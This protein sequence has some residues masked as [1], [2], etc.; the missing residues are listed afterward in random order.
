[1]GASSEHTSDLL[2]KQ[3]EIQGSSL[4]LSIEST[5][6]FDDPI[7]LIILL[8]SEL[9]HD[10]QY[11]LALD[12]HPWTSLSD[13]VHSASI[14]EAQPL[15][16]N[17]SR[18]WPILTAIEHCRTLYYRIAFLIPVS[19]K[20]FVYCKWAHIIHPGIRTLSALPKP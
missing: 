3:T 1:V 7:A 20:S 5:Y 15:H 13:M 4:N 11:N 6:S 12:Q 2:R 17:L 9:K 16:R 14:I 8:C 19:I 18:S 10:V